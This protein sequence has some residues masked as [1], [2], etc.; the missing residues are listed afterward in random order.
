MA[1][2]QCRFRKY[3]SMLVSVRSAFGE[4]INT[5]ERTVR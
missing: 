2:N 1:F 3:I 4:N 5:F